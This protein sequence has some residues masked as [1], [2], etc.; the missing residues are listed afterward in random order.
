MSGR[1]GVVSERCPSWGDEVLG[2]VRHDALSSCITGERGGGMRCCWLDVTTWGGAFALISLLSFFSQDRGW[3]TEEVNAALGK[4]RTA[5]HKTRRSPET[6]TNA[7]K[8]KP[9]ARACLQKG[10]SRESSIQRLGRQRVA[11]NNQCGIVRR[12]E[13]R[14]GG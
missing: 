11:L 12:L 5:S 1:V 13:R 8:G 3:G 7:T 6:M 10:R 9:S 2:C 14:R 4:Q